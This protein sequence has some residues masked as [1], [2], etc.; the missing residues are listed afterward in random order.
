M[1]AGA[2]S[3]TAGM[4]SSVESDT[5]YQFY[6]TVESDQPAGGGSYRTVR[7]TPAST[8]L[9]PA[10]PARPRQARLGLDVPGTAAGLKKQANLAVSGGGQERGGRLGHP[11]EATEGGRRRGP[12]RPDLVDGVVATEHRL[13]R[14]APLNQK[15]ASH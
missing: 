12:R 3:A 6:Q 9:D 1:R 7:K 4:F 13:A 11:V 14:L 2:L 15:P 5:F 8:D 10:D